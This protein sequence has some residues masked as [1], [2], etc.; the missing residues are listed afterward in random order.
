MSLSVVDVKAVLTDIIVLRA[1]PRV[2]KSPLKKLR[3]EAARVQPP[4]TPLTLHRAV[5]DV[6]RLSAVALLSQA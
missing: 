6:D 5:A 4:E 3:P 1:P 2:A